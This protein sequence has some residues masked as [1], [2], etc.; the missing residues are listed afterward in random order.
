MEKRFK[1]KAGNSNFDCMIEGTEEEIKR[2]EE[3]LEK[4]D[5]N[6]SGGVE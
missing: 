4:Q 1:A 2:F 6:V 3:I 5:A